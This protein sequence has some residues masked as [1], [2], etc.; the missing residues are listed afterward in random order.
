VHIFI[1]S[2]LLLDENVIMTTIYVK[3]QHPDKDDEEVTKPWFDFQPNT[4]ADKKQL[5]SRAGMR[6][7][8][9]SAAIA[10]ASKK[11]LKYTNEDFANE[12]NL[13]VKDDDGNLELLE[14]ESDYKNHADKKKIYAY[15]PAPP[16]HTT[17]VKRR[18][19]EGLQQGKVGVLWMC[20]WI[21]LLCIRVTDVCIFFL[22]HTREQQYQPTHTERKIA[23]QL[24]HRE[25]D[26]VHENQ[27]TWQGRWYTQYRP[28]T[29]NQR[30]RCHRTSGSARRP[31]R[32]HARTGA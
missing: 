23:P 9:A 7:L 29:S 16:T 25:M 4:D 6:E 26:K 1:P 15:V 10:K 30:T 19:D 27:Y 21:C 24:W 14:D 13:Y 20:L 8:V 31:S 32:I 5:A 22:S 12:V 17:E 11:E 2:V 28:S 3:K 18:G